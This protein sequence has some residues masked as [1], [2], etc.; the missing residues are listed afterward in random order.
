MRVCG[1][2]GGVEQACA[3]HSLPNPLPGRARESGLFPALAA[4]LVLAGLLSA[5]RTPA[6]PGTT[7]RVSISSYGEQANGDSG[8]YFGVSLSADARFVAFCSVASNLVPDDTNGHWDLFVRDRHLGTTER[9][10]VSSSG[11]QAD[12]GSGSPSQTA[13]GRFVVFFSYATNLVPEDT[14]GY[15]DAFVRDRQLG[16]TERISVSSSGNQANGGSYC[17]SVSADGRFVAFLSLATNLV[18]GGTGPWSQVFVRDRLR[19]TTEL[20][21]VSLSGEPGDFDSYYCSVSADGRFVAFLSSAGNLVPGGTIGKQKVFVHDLLTGTNEQASVSSSGEPENGLSWWCCVSE[22][23]RFVA[24]ESDAT[25]L[26]PGDANGDRDVF[27]RDRLAGTTERVSVSSSGGEGN[28]PSFGPSISSDGRYVS[29]KSSAS[30]LVTGDANGCQDVFLRDRLAG[31]TELVSVSSRGEQGN[32]DSW[33]SCL[34][35]DGR[36]VAFTSSA[37]NLVAGDTNGC[38]DVF[39]RDRQAEY[40]DVCGLVAFQGLDATATPPVSAAVSVTWHGTVFG[41]YDAD[42]APDGSYSLLLPAGALTLSVRHTHWLRQTVDADNSGGPVD[43]VDFTLV[44]GDCYDDNAVDL[45]DLAQ[46]LVYFGVP[47]PLADLDEDGLVG[48][49]DLDI[50]LRNFGEI[51]DG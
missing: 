37:A 34:S 43:G 6:Q 1:L 44:N 49:A 15:C 17:P 18:P 40:Y 36:Y 32:L 25:N 33:A 22:D 38:W 2:P 10:S 4:L 28:G 47:H 21:S 30:N 24:F 51:G 41:T 27:V 23:G 5:A 14:N 35:A 39:V 12:A 19:G 9:V 20:A 8:W 13:D 29:Y 31:G 11:A 7:Q 45:R 50:V 3:L 48:P 46:V 26:V 16:T 42:L